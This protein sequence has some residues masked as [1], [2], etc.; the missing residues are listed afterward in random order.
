MGD[1]MVAGLAVSLVQ[2]QDVV[3]GLRLG[4]AAGAAAA[5][6]TGTALALPTEIARLLPEVR[7]RELI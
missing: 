7:V 4:T 1:S 2:G 6:T 5:M 3:E